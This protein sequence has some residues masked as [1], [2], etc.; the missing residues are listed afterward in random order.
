VRN[1]KGFCFKEYLPFFPLGCFIFLIHVKFKKFF[2]KS[3]CWV[4][5]HY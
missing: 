1:H 5:G 2:Y 4:K 3:L